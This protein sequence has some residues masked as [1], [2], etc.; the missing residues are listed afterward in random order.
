MELQ[1]G[2][3]QDLDVGA[4]QLAALAE[5]LVQRSKAAVRSGDLKDMAAALE[6]VVSLSRRNSVAVP[7]VL[8]VIPSKGNKIAVQ[9]SDPLGAPLADAGECAL[10]AASA[11]EL[12]G[13]ADATDLQVDFEF[14]LR[15]SKKSTK[16]VFTSSDALTALNSENTNAF[17]MDLTFSPPDSPTNGPPLHTVE[18]TTRVVRIPLAGSVSSGSVLVSTS[19]KAQDDDAVLSRADLPGQ[20]S[21][22][23]RAGSAHFVHVVFSVEANGKSFQP[24]QAVL[25][26]SPQKGGQDAFFA[27]RADAAGLRATINV[28]DRREL[29]AAADGGTFQA[30][31]IIGDSRL[32]S[33][34]SV[35]IG[36]V[37]LETPAPAPTP[38]EILYAKPLLH[39]SDTAIAPLKE[40]IHQFNPDEKQPPIIVPTVVTGGLLVVLAAFVLGVLALGHT[41]RSPGLA[42]LL[43]MAVIIAMIG[44]LGLYFLQ[45]GPVDNA[46]AALG[47]LGLLTVPGLFIGRA[48]LGGLAASEG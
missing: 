17:E 46:F 9:V 41:W 29:G 4:D 1:A 14:T 20:G 36:L 13:P 7:V 42:G 38:E 39:E 5:A 32:L 30:S 35:P 31:I 22:V 34:V 47:L 2:T 16:T 15:K 10:R 33:G 24:H 8:T 44:V 25:R 3:S 12:G 11:R 26:L 40:I 21:A 45:V 6:G 18:S 28:G 23:I 27:A 43:L 19:S 48:A 37:T